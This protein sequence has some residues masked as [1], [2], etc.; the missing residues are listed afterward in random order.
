MIRTN[1]KYAPE[2]TIA[3][4]AHQTDL[5]ID[6]SLGKC[7]GYPFLQPPQHCANLY[8]LLFRTIQ[9]VR[10]GRGMLLPPCVSQW[11]K[12]GEVRIPYGGVKIECIWRRFCLPWMDHFCCCLLLLEL[13]GSRRFLGQILCSLR[14]QD[15]HA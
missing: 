6:V 13:L 4:L 7:G 11:V 10:H 5:I 8:D 1:S 2:R 12:E 15:V 14:Y 9:V 3:S